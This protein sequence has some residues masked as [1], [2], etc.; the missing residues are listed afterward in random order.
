MGWINYAVVPKW[1]LAFPISRHA[2]FIDDD[3]DRY[4]DALL[5]F[6][7]NKQALETAFQEVTVA[8]MMEL[9]EVAEAA[10]MVDSMDE[11]LLYWLR[12][13]RLAFF[14]LTEDEFEQRRKQGELK[15]IR[16]LTR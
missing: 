10:T 2:H 7:D 5:E 14:V 4:I 8:Q 15:K 3:I 13:S 9:S 11:L 16:L 6:D 12:K 1:R